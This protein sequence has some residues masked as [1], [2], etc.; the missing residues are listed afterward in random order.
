MVQYKQHI[1]DQSHYC[2]LTVK[3]VKHTDKVTVHS[4]TKEE[5][6]LCGCG[7]LHMIL[8]NICR[9][10]QPI[11]WLSNLYSYFSFWF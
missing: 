3:K 1:S 8:K 6:Q 9:L 10:A 4:E 11:L 2:L 7:L 5:K